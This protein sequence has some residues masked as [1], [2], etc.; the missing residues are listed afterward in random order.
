MVFVL[1]SNRQP[2]DPCHPA[3]ARKLLTAGKAAV[4]RR[5]PFTIILQDRSTGT[6]ITHNHRI[7]LDPGSRTTGLAVVNDGTGRVVWV[8]EL[9][10]RGQQIRDALLSRRQ[11]RRSRR[12]RKT[13]YRQARFLNRTRRAGW[14]PPS[15]ESRVASILT[16]VRRLV[17][18]CPVAAISTELVR[19]DTQVMQN[20]EIRGVDYQQG[21]LQ[22][23]EVREYVLEKWGRKCAY[24]GADN[25]PLEVEHIIPRSRSGS[26][27][28]SNLTLAC[29]ECN[30]EKDNLT[31]EEYGALKR[32][33]FSHITQQAKAP[34]KDTAAVNAT[35]WSLYE[36]LKAMGLPI[37]TGSGGRTKY[38]R[39]RLGLPKTHWLD[40]A[41]VGASTP[42]HLGVSGIT[43]LA[44]KA[45]GHGVRQT[46]QPDKFG[47]PKGHRQR[48]KHYF[49][50]QT[51]D[52]ARAV[53]TSGKKAG[54]YVGRVAVRA[55]GS[56]NIQTSDGTV[57]GLHYR[58][59][60]PIHRADGYHYGV[61]APFW[62]NCTV[63]SQ[64]NIKKR[65]VL[66]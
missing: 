28:V 56:F 12:S 61:I 11:L 8:A 7:K 46:A 35:H 64:V 54:T 9:A 2:L 34:L 23:Y 60:H 38:N 49:G 55:T 10:H 42:D 51:G 62:V 24:C 63:R 44:I 4:I 21:E 52:M 32:K 40:A 41:C 22:G 66:R 29:H 5:Y 20:P 37:E 31:A 3:R 45:T 58:F 30:L 48:P 26:D 13:R 33:D 27:R 57:Q 39:T 6:S 19:F 59:F 16:W 25:V 53:V 14:L 43:P 65:R 1:D 15:L 50:F 47:F 18:F 17:Q 36:R